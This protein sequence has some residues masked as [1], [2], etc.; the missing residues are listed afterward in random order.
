MHVYRVVPVM[1]LFSLSSVV[2][3]ASDPDVHM[4]DRLGIT[5]TLMLTATAYSLVIADGL[6]TLGYL[7][8][9]D[10]YILLTF[11]FIAL[12]SSEITII[13]WVNN[14]HS[15][16]MTHQLYSTE[17]TLEFASYVSLGLWVFMHIGMFV[18]HSHIFQCPLFSQPIKSAEP[19]LCKR[20]PSSFHASTLYD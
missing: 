8:F 17:D 18:P 10:K 3:F 20:Q 7:T 5:L 9:L 2:A 14:R 15:T 19:P 6:P 13:E 1:A 12:I 11:G 4:F 16:N